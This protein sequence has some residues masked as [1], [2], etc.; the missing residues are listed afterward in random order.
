MGLIKWNAKFATGITR[1]D[2]EHQQLVAM[3]ND[4]HSAM[5]QGQTRQ[6]LE[7]ILG[8]LA[9]YV[10]FHFAGEEQLMRSC[11]YPNYAAHCAAHADF[12]SKVEDF[13][14]K[15]D[16]DR[17]SLPIEL[18]SFLQDWLTRHILEEDMLYVPQMQQLPQ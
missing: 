9:D 2:T 10:L 16:Q 14:R 15:F 7:K 12:R 5:R 13:R 6:V 17:I 8:D 18:F 3:V 11:Q 1:V 4:L